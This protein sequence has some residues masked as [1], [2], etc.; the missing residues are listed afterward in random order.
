MC[1]CA[2]PS[3]VPA[4]TMCTLDVERALTASSLGAGTFNKQVLPLR[5]D[6]Q[7]EFPS[8]F[9]RGLPYLAQSRPRNPFRYDTLKRQYEQFPPTL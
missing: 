9:S 3:Y 2:A 6:R 8:T 1:G 5:G 4:T 7:K